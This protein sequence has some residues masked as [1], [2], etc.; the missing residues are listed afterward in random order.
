M[1]TQWERGNSTTHA[2]FLKN[3]FALSTGDGSLRRQSVP[4]KPSNKTKHKILFKQFKFQ[5]WVIQ[6]RQVSN[7]H[8]R[9]TQRA[10][11]LL[12]WGQGPELRKIYQLKNSKTLCHVEGTFQNIGS[13]PGAASRSKPWQPRFRC[14]I[15]FIFVSLDFFLF[16][17]VLLGPPNSAWG[18]GG[19][20]PGLPA[21]VRNSLAW[22]VW[23]LSGRLRIFKISENI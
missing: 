14:H 18:P 3:Q 10:R 23:T 22:P 2:S 13:H 8:P 6:H 9:G 5:S 12:G 1:M 21:E 19:W 7:L 4:R 15:T 20:G 16:C 11:E 17:N